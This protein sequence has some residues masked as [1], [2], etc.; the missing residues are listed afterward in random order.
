M[1]RIILLT[2]SLITIHVESF[3]YVKVEGDTNCGSVSNRK[4]ILDKAACE[5]AATSMGLDDVV[6]DEVSWSYATHQDV[7]GYITDNLYYNTL[8]TST[9]SCTTNSDFCLC[10]AAS[11][12]TQ[13]N[14][15]TSNTDA[16][17]C[18]GTGLCTAAS[19]L[20]CYA[21]NSQCS[22]VA[23]P[24]CLTTDG[25]AANGALA[26]AEAPNVRQPPVSSATLKQV[27]APLQLF[28]DLCPIRDGSAANTLRARAGVW[29]AR[30][31]WINL[32]FDVWRWVVSE[33]GLRSIR[34]S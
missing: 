15:A 7:S 19:G 5:A 23:I 13:T 3:S 22:L 26:R 6:A 31:D 33:D 24:D 25:S 28:S 34:L 29:S 18:G 12:C 1:H 27:S 32:L 21:S 4:P 10:I 11:D 2:L 14:G 9:A 30:V 17:L 16:C 20:F 8:S